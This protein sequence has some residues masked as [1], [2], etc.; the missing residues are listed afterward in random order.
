MKAS[1]AQLKFAPPISDPSCAEVRGFPPLSFAPFRRLFQVALL[2]CCFF[3]FL[4]RLCPSAVGLHC[5]L[6][7]L[8]T[9]VQSASALRDGLSNAF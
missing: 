2:T 3:A 4:L 1:Q 9:C 8:P 6:D 5:L 7:E